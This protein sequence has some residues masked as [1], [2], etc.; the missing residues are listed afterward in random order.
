MA[1]T[2]TLEEDK[3]EVVGEYKAVQIRTGT[4]F[5]VDG[6]DISSAF[7]LNSLHPGTLDASDNLVNTNISGESTDVK[8]ICNTVW[9][10]AVKDSWKAHL[11]ANKE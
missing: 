5:L 1:L 3:I 7:H 6:A 9:T 11:I 2:K 8:G 4:V 10:S